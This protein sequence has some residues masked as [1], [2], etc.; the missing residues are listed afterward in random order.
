MKSFKSVKQARPF[1]IPA[2]GPKPKWTG[3]PF[4]VYVL[5]ISICGF[6]MVYN[7]PKI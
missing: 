1:F 5:A 3:L 6:I 2:P 4:W 7:V